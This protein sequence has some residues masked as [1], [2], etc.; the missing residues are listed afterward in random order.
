[1][2]RPR[3][4]AGRIPA[5]VLRIHVSR[6]AQLLSLQDDQS[7]RCLGPPVCSTA[8]TP[9]LTFPS[10]LKTLDH[11]VR[12][13]M[14]GSLAS[15]QLRDSIRAC[16]FTDADLLR[17]R[18]Q[19]SRLRCQRSL[20]HSH[21]TFDLSSSPVDGG[22]NCLFAQR[23]DPVPSVVSLNRLRSYRVRLPLT[24][25][26]VTRQ[27]IERISDGRTVAP[28]LTLINLRRLAVAIKSW[29][30]SPEKST[31]RGYETAHG[32]NAQRTTHQLHDDRGEAESPCRMWSTIRSSFHDVEDR[33]QLCEPNH[34]YI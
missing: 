15:S 14:C 2:L 31:V 21:R 9:Q 3:N 11:H 8:V 4:A 24:N 17:T 30:T 20:R 27:S 29:N 33:C 22:R 26:H 13:A 34:A 23:E 16:A 18:V 12:W 6:A 7:S 25:N 19:V 28:A 32:M 1:M 5:F 10:P